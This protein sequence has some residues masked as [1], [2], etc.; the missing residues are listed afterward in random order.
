MR[1]GGEGG[2]VGGRDV[3]CSLPNC[4][5]LCAVFIGL[6]PVSLA[7]RARGWR[8]TERMVEGGDG[9]GREGR[10][11]GGAVGGRVPSSPRCS[12]RC[13]SGSCLSRSSPSVYP[14]ASRLIHAATSKQRTAQ[15]AA[16][17]TAHTHG[18]IRASSHTIKSHA[19]WHR[20]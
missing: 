2:A 12:V 6:V 8:E 13:S 10:W 11:E 4:S 3:V 19:Q 18:G 15:H 7:P 16:Q 14:A 9:G 17:H 5:V 1:G 20:K